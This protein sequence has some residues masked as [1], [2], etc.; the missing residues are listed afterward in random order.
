MDIRLSFLSLTLGA[1]LVAP[2]IATACDIALVLAVDVSGSVDSYEYDLQA[3]GIASAI[4][5]PD[6]QEAMVRGQVALAVLQWSG[7]LEQSLSIP[8]TRVSEPA[9]AMALAHR[10]S[11]MPRGHVGGNTAVG[12]AVQVAAAL[13]EQVADC[14]HWVIDV[15]GDGNENEGFNIGEERANAWRQGIA[16]NGLAIEG[17]ASGLSVT[18]FY[19]RHVVTPGSFVITASNHDDFARA[20]Q[21]KMLRELIPPMAQAPGRQAVRLAALP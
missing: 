10:V 4:R 5:D 9:E 2:S 17:A 18:N 8:W 14:R 3:Q 6:V 13:F 20:M 21:E 12:E 19:R 7:A 11:R 16:I 1:T 15:S